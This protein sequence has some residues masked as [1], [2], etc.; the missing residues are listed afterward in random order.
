MSDK[1]YLGDGVYVETLEGML[2]LETEALEETNTIFL[3]PEVMN[4]LI[5]YY[6][7]LLG[8]DTL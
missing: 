5:N 6:K 2:K 8:V 1:Q 7:K 4:R 3:E